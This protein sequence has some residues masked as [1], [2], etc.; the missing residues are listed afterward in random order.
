VNVSLIKTIIKVEKKKVEINRLNQ[1]RELINKKDIDAVL[2]SSR[3]NTYYFTGFT[4]TTSKFL[5]TTD[6]AYIIV[7]FR[8][9]VQAEGQVYK[10]IE[11][12]EYEKGAQDTLSDLCSTHGVEVL[13]IE[14]DDVSF[15]EYKTLQE[16]LCTAKSIL[17][18]QHEINQIRVIKDDDEIAFIQKAVDI[19][20]RAFEEILPY[21]KPGVKE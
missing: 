14:G 13:G 2:L 6:K 21:I 18:I 12:I 7:D 19:A 15:A 16:K 4:G 1:L 20:D 9:T 17:D 10:G 5:L 3:S 8:Y 11:V